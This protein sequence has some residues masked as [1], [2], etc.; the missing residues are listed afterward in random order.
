MLSKLSYLP[1]LA[2]LLA[3]VLFAITVLL[4]LVI[5]KLPFV[6]FASYV[7]YYIYIYIYIYIC[8]KHIYIYIYI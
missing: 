5:K 2:H 4:L 1:Y 8:N 6:V 7:A 3:N